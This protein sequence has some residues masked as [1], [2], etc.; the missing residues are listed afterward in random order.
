MSCVI[1]L[2]DCTTDIS[3]LRVD[4]SDCKCKYN[5]HFECMENYLKTEEV[6]LMCKKKIFC[7]VNQ[8]NPVIINTGEYVSLDIPGTP[9]EREEPLTEGQQ[10]IINNIVSG[11]RLN[12]WCENNRRALGILFVSIVCIY[13]T[14][15]VF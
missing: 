12:E 10:Q 13:F 14:L 6:C 15:S 11:D 8:I 5:V 9:E 7:T 3:L 4:N 2:D 1:C